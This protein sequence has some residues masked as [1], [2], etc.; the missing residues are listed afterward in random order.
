METRV[1]PSIPRKTYTASTSIKKEISLKTNSAKV[2][3][4]GIQL[5][6]KKI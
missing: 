3:S 5:T 1:V 4:K 2:L 6:K